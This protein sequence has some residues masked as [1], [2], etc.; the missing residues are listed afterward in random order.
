M[1]APAVIAPAEEDVR[2]TRVP[3]ETAGKSRPFC[4]LYDECV[5]LQNRHSVKCGNSSSDENWESRFLSISGMRKGAIFPGFC[6]IVI[7]IPQNS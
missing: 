1:E 3:S 5:V 7:E 2:G 6:R 4:A